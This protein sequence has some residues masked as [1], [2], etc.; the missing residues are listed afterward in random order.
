MSLW[1]LWRPPIVTTLFLL[2]F[3]YVYFHCHANV[4]L[5][6]IKFTT[7]TTWNYLYIPK[8]Q[9][10]NRWSLGM[11]KLFHPIFYNGCNCLSMLGLK[12]NHVSKRGHRGDSFG[13]KQAI[14]KPWP[15]FHQFPHWVLPLFPLGCVF[16]PYS[17]V[18]LS[19]LAH[20]SLRPLLIPGYKEITHLHDIWANQTV[21]TRD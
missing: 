20:Q 3:N 15:T 17:N 9:R 8:L 10:C 18:T 13:T 4:V 5:L 1:L 19:I 7:T 12:L 6:E 2:Y 14:G 11:D 16:V 21:M